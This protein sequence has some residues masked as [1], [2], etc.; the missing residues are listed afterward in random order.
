MGLYNSINLARF[1]TYAEAFEFNSR[2]YLR[3]S[4]A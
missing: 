3:L 4:L 1:K 2:L